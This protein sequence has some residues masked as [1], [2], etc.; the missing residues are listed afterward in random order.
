MFCGSCRE[1]RGLA[2]DNTDYYSDDEPNEQ[3]MVS[4]NFSLTQVF[5]C[6]NKV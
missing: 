4:T 5:P 2:D 3:D 1:I 6:G